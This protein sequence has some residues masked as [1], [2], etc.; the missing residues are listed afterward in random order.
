[1]GLRPTKEVKINGETFEGK[2]VVCVGANAGIG[3]AKCDYL[4]ENKVSRLIMACRST[5]KAE[6]ARQEVVK[7]IKNDSTTVEVWKIDLASLSSCREFASKWNANPDNKI[8]I[9]YLN[10]G[11]IAPNASLIT[12]EDGLEMT[13][14][15]NVLGHLAVIEQLL[16][17]LAL[18]DDPRII[19]TG[20]SGAKM[21]TLPDHPGSNKRTPLRDAWSIGSY[22]LN[23]FNIYT[24]TKLL[25]AMVV[26]ELQESFKNHP[27]EKYRKIF[28]ANYHPGFVKTTIS[29]K[30][31]YG[32]SSLLSIPVDFLTNRYA[33]TPEVGARPGLYLGSAS[34][35]QLPGGEFW[36]ENAEP[37]SLTAQYDNEA[38]RREYFERCIKDAGINPSTFPLP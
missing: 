36:D 13:Y 19:F 6:K 29:N 14:A 33:I 28:V 22:V 16:P 30:D 20:S 2:T 32:L 34:I 11:L 1:M 21:S 35:E 27:D 15:C 9:L 4:V 10:A 25:L 38:L 17:S 5:D 24:D 23:A 12:S 18:S 3:L 7:K 8:D 37:A 31:H 26:R